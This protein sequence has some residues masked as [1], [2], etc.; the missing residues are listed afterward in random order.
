MIFRASGLQVSVHLPDESLNVSGDTLA[1]S[2][3]VQDT[4]ASCSDSSNPEV[5]LDMPAERLRIWLGIVQQLKQ[6]STPDVTTPGV[7][8]LATQAVIHGILVRFNA[9]KFMHL[10]FRSNLYVVVYL[11]ATSPVHELLSAEY[12]HTIT[13]PWFPPTNQL[14]ATVLMGRGSY[15]VHVECKSYSVQQLQCVNNQLPRIKHTLHED[16]PTQFSSLD[17]SS[18]VSVSHALCSH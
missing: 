1:R 17:T 3:L 12:T 10:C 7:A 5:R 18:S 4:L 14:H 9:L 13:C 8:S 11:L 16:F 2:R 6:V 15:C